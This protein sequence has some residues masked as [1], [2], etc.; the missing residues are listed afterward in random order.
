[1]KNDGLGVLKEYIVDISVEVSQKAK[2]D[3]LRYSHIALGYIPKGR[4][5]IL[6]QRFL[7]HVHCYST[8]KSKEMETGEMSIKRL[9]DNKNMA[10]TR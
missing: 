5:C 2:L 3:L 1:M 6:L 7:I 10:F 8:H 4:L 9:I